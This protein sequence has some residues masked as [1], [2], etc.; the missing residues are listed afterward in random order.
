MVESRDPGWSRVDSILAQ[1]LERPEQ[2]RQAWIRES[3]GADAAL[4]AE[5]TRLL[6]L[7]S[8]EDGTLDSERLSTLW[9]DALGALEGEPLEEEP[10]LRPGQSIG[11]YQVLGVLGRGGMGTVYRARDATLGREVVVKAVSGTFGG[12]PSGLKRFGREARLLASLNHPNIATIYD[13]LE[14]E[15]CPYLILELVEGETLADRIARGPLPAD[16]CLRVARQLA[17]ALEEAHEKGV[18]HRDLK[19][20]NV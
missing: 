2:E 1:A 17:E 7:G 13:L 8:R 9:E 11:P 5:V 6:E 15:G 18:V 10:G 16:E 4:A 20:S 12:D 19:P 3:C 14:L